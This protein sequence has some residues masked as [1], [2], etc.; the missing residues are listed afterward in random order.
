MKIRPLLSETC[1]Q[2]FG[3]EFPSARKGTP[4]RAEATRKLLSKGKT[5]VSA[6]AGRMVRFRLLLISDAGVG[7]GRSAIPAGTNDGTCIALEQQVPVSVN[8]LRN[9]KPSRKGWDIATSNLLPL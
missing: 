5:T 9:T 7:A 4:H 1:T 8:T 2:D 6:A 3:C